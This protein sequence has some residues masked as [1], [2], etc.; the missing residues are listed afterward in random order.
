MRGMFYTY[1]SELSSNS[2]KNADLVQPN[3]VSGQFSIVFSIVSWMLSNIHG[4]R[5]E[6]TWGNNEAVLETNAFGEKLMYVIESL[7]IKIT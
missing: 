3:F 6:E 5:E 7:T 1:S 4:Q 2:S